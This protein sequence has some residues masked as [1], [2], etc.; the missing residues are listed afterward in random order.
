MIQEEQIF[1]RYVLNT[2]LR[3]F[4]LAMIL[5]IY[6]EIRYLYVSIF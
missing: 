1:L 5:L 6:Y 4:F 3:H 2:F